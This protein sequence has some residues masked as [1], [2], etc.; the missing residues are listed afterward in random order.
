MAMDIVNIFETP[1]IVFR[2]LAK[3]AL[4]LFTSILAFR[5]P[6][7]IQEKRSS[8]SYDI[9]PRTGFFPAKPLARLPSQ[10]N[11][12][13]NALEDA[14]GN[15]SLGEDA[16]EDA[17]AKHPFGQHWRAV[18]SSVSFQFN[19]SLQLDINRVCLTYFSGQSST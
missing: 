14:R 6:R 3:F 7:V 15:I 5:Y 17:V 8:A 16:S 2:L 19:F 10:Y 13:E 1:P 4:S 9:D 18:I 11:L 12:W